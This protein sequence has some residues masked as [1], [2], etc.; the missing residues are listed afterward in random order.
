MKVYIKYK[1]F[2]IIAALLFIHGSILLSQDLPKDA[3]RF[4]PESILWVDA[5]PSLPA[6]AKVFILEGNPQQEGI[7]TM[8]VKFPPYYKLP[9]HTHPK[10]ERV[11]V[12]E[13]AVYVGFGN[14][15]DTA[16]AQKFTVGSYYLN[17]VNEAHYVFTGEEGVIFQVTGMG[18]W[19]L[20]YIDEKD[21]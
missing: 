21:N 15:I 16:N 14:A 4:F 13:G 19:G 12:L 11:T 3:I 18:P 2:S 17:P 5:P 1:Q 9:A 6:G 20:E 7:F 8:R 10:D